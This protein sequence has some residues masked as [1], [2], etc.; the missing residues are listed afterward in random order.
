MPSTTTRAC[1]V[2]ALG[3]AR[4]LLQLERAQRADRPDQLLGE[5]I[6]HLGHPAQHDRL[7][8]LG[9]G[10]V[11]VQEQ[12]AALECLGQLTGRVRGQH[13]EGL[14]GRLDRAELG[15][16]DL[17]VREHLEQQALDLDV[18]LVGLVDE[19]NR[20]L[21]LPDRGQQRAGEQ[22]LLGEDVVVGFFPRLLTGGLDAQQLLAV[23]PLIERARLVESLVALQ[24]HQPGGGG[25][26][27]GLRQLGLAGAGR[28]LR[29][30]A[31][32]QARRPGTPSSRWRRRR[33]SRS[34]PAAPGRPRAKRTTTCG[35]PFHMAR[36]SLRLDS[37]RDSMRQ[38][39]CCA[40]VVCPRWPRRLSNR[41]A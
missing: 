31:A 30:T 28:A 37:E 10:V 9:V 25:G 26:C 34:R 32:C 27:D 17:E 14:A 7:L 35:A 33:G 23:V 22:E 39:C 3:D 5:R 2:D 8:A 11:E 4:C 13:D 21:G 29:P 41:S 20:R 24:P 36:R 15:N 38:P 6:D 1:P 19:Q 18:G 40:A 16:G 12:A